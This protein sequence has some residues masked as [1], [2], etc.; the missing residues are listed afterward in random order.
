MFSGDVYI[1]PLRITHIP[2]LRITHL[3]QNME[4]NKVIVIIII[5]II[6]MPRPWGHQGLTRRDFYVKIGGLKS[7]NGGF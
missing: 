4:H 3:K 2:P 1:P 7:Q 6:I 5:I